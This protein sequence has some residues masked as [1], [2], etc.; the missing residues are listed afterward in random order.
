M[1]YKPREVL[2]KLER[3]GFQVH[4]HKGS[5]HCFLRH[6]DGRQTMV[7]MHSKEVPDGTF[8]SILK[9]SGLTLEEFRKL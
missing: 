3:A 9:Q 8:R 7:A 1:P 2:A 5:S 4:R 6:S